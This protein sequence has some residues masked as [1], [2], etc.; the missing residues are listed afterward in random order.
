MFQIQLSKFNIQNID[1]NE[2]LKWCLVRYFNPADHRPERIRKI[3][4]ELAIKL[5]FKDIKYL[6]KISDIHKF[7]KKIVSVLAFLVMGITKNFQSTF[8]KIF[9]R[10]MLIYY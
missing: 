4:K 6:V 3:D 1:D 8:Q 5:D 7:E 2:C 9:S 10:D